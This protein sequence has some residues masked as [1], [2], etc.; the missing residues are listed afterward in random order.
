[1]NILEVIF[2]TA[3]ATIGG[4]AALMGALYFLTKKLLDH[5]LKKDIENFKNQL[6]H[7]ANLEI[8]KT[9][10][11]YRLEAEKFATSLQAQTAAEIEQLKTELQKKSTEHNISFSKLHEKRSESS[12]I[13][14]K[15]LSELRKNTE[16]MLYRTKNEADLSETIELAQ[17]CASASNNANALLNQVIIYFPED[18]CQKI[19]EVMFVLSYPAH[20]ALTS[21]E[22]QNSSK[23]ARKEWAIEYSEKLRKYHPLHSEILTEFRRF[24]NQV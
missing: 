7:T 14:T 24:L 13:M 6:Q 11:N 18:L 8:I 12:E 19:Q 3:I 17:D 2:T 20:I 22:L 10:H 9:E 15:A 5:T 1:M 16:K 21:S 23:K 4:S